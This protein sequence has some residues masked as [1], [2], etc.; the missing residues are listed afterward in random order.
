MTLFLETLTNLDDELKTYLWSLERH[1]EQ[2]DRRETL[3]DKRPR[4]PSSLLTPQRHCPGIDASGTSA[5][6]SSVMKMGYMNM[7]FVMLRPW[8][9]HAR[10]TGCW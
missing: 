2:N 9:C 8:F 10:V 1:T 4:K 5:S 7:D 3:L 6:S